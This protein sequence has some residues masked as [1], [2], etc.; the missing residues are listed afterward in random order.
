MTRRSGAPFWATLCSMLVAVSLSTTACADSNNNDLQPNNEDRFTTESTEEG[1]RLL[2]DE[3]EL[4]G[5]YGDYQEIEVA[6]DEDPAQ[7]VHWDLLFNSLPAGMHLAE[8]ERNRSLIYGTPE[9]TGTW[10]FVLGARVDQKIRATSNICLHAEENTALEYPKFETGRKLPNGQV[11]EDYKTDIDIDLVSSWDSYDAELFESELPPGMK[12]RKRF[13]KNA[14]KVK[15]EPT[16]SGLFNFAFQIVDGKGRK[17][18]RQFELRILEEE[19]PGYSCPPGY[20]YDDVVGHCVQDKLDTCPDGTYYD[21]EENQCIQYPAPPPTIRCQSGYYY[22]HY[23]DRCVRLGAPRC[24]NNY[25]WDSF[26]GRCTRLP[27]TCRI[28]ERYD[29]DLE[30]CVRRRHH[31]ICPIDSYWDS[32]YGRC[33]SRNRMCPIGS[34]WS[35]VAGRCIR[36]GR[37]CRNGDLWDPARNRC[38]GRVRYCGPGKVWDSVYGR[39]VRTGPI[40]RRCEGN[41]R[42]DPV[43]GRCVIFRRPNPHPRPTP[44]IRPNPRPRPRPTPPPVRPN[45]RPRP[46]PPPVRPNPRPRPTPPPVRPNPRPRPTPPPVRPNP[47]PR[48]TPPPVRPNPRPRPTPPPVRPN[49]RPRPTPP[50]VRPNPRPR[51]T[52]T[53]PRVRPN[54]RPRPNPGNPP[55]RPGRPRRP[56]RR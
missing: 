1:G 53:P 9:F 18:T 10:C 46:T 32:Y 24:P 27:Y 23:I 2:Y 17:N 31:R 36:S 50:P 40:R 44:P 52:P 34:H 13:S 5:R 47:R 38:V 7:P 21:P 12:W 16:E 19:E 8:V 4:V 22:D 33:V 25:H 35:R 41:R 49:P 26:R 45:P 48:P 51:P 3:Q 14:I 56:P 15:E 30:M 43:L 42:W 6:L 55:G 20:Y 29:W 37:G 11:N 28:G 39:C 54:P